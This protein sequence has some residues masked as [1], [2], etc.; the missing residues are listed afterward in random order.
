[1]LFRS[2]GEHRWN[3]DTR[4]TADH[5]IPY[6]V[7]ATLMDG[8]VTPR[9]FNHARLWHPELRAL[10][11][12]IEVV[13]N[14]AFT[15]A[16]IKHPVEHRTRVTVLTQ[17]G[18]KLSGEVGGDENDL[19]KPKSDA[20]INEKFRTLCEDSLGVKQSRAIL[21]SLW[22]LDGMTDVSA[23]PPAFVIA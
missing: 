6:V 18:E 23:I 8:T 9:S 7:A 2:T 3:P 20:M 19:S 5:S 4:E 15:Q 10:I 22:A 14:E 11:H 21:D 16:Y 12:K 1:M 13:E 17:N